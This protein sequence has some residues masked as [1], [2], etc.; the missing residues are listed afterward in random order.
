[1]QKAISR[2]I[3][4]LT[5]ILASVLAILPRYI[6]IKLILLSKLRYLCTLTCDFNLI[7]HSIHIIEGVLKTGLRISEIRHFY[8]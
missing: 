4:W 8:H 5:V 6:T 1:M 7:K 3:F 2:H